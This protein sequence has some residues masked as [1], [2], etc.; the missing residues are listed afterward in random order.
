MGIM[1]VKE[2]KKQEAKRQESL[3]QVCSITSGLIIFLFM[4]KVTVQK[5]G[6]SDTIDLGQPYTLPRGK[7]HRL[8]GECWSRI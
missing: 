3:P 2:M 4:F 8:N 5:V 7:M 6:L 1:V